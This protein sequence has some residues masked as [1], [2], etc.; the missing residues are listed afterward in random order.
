MTVNKLLIR[1]LFK[2][3]GF[4][5]LKAI[6]AFIDLGAIGTTLLD[7]LIILRRR[8]WRHLANVELGHVSFREPLAGAHIHGHLQRQMLVVVE[9]RLA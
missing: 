8:D 3:I 6:N 7:E 5:P 1:Y 9:V 4:G 2:V